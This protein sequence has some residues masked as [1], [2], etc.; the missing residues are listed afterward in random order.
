[1][2]SYFNVHPH[3]SPHES[4]CNR[5]GWR[6]AFTYSITVVCIRCGWYPSLLTCAHAFTPGLNSV[7]HYFTHPL[8]IHLNFEDIQAEDVG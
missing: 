3:R 7:S 8:F 5:V 1:M 4:G 2:C 6:Y